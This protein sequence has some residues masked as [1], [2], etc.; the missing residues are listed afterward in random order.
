MRPSIRGLHSLPE[1]ERI[2][3]IGM[4]VLEKRAI[5]GCI[6]DSDPGK[7][8]RYVEKMKRFHPTVRHVDTQPGPVPN[9]V[10]IRF[11]PPLAG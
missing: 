7:A 9:T 5:V 10:M 11:G 2:K 6:T 8:K 3:V 1:D 4:T